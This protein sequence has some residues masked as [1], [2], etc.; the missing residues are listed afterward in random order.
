MKIFFN[1]IA[2]TD[3]RALR[4]ASE[5]LEMARNPK[6]DD[7]VVRFRTAWHEESENKSRYSLGLEKRSATINSIPVLKIDN[8]LVTNTKSILQAL[9]SELEN[10]NGVKK[11]VPRDV[12][13]Y[14]IQ[15][16]GKHLNNDKKEHFKEPISFDELTAALR[17][18]KRGNHLALTGIRLVF[19]N[20]SGN[21]LVPFY[22]EVF[23][24]LSIGNR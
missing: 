15:N 24:T 9:S 21:K 7:L 3:E 10:K 6:I 2:E 16:C 1:T 4:V 5:E 18:M 17:K 8:Q 19:T 13:D 11:L 22:T 23:T 14:L 20:I 12:N